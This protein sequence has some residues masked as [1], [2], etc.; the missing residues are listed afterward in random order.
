MASDEPSWGQIAGEWR[1]A[2]ETK[3]PH[4]F[5]PQDRSE[6]S[7]VDPSPHLG[8]SSVGGR[9]SISEKLFRDRDLGPT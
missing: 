7:G 4:C 9:G 8:S 1:K 2:W 5:R 3:S 6:E